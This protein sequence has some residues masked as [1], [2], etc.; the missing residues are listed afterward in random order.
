MTNKILVAYASRT[1]STAGV[2]EAIGKT[3]AERTAQVDVCSMQHVRDLNPYCAVVLGSAIQNKQWL[4]EALRFVRT[5]HT[6][7]NQK[8]C[9]VF[10]VCM[11]LAIGNGKYLKQAESFLDPLRALVRPV[12]EG[13]FAG[14]LDIRKVPALKDRLLFRLSVVLGV[15][16]QGDHRN[17]DAIHAWTES[18]APLL[19]PNR[20]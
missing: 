19:L 6:A 2:A 11:T 7:L 20:K 8:P 17:W 14:V 13:Y 3:L 5:H 15:W 16:S 10:L 18:I 1:G 9:A 4:P 12:A